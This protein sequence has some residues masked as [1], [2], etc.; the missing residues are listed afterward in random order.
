MVYIYIY[1]YKPL[2]VKSLNARLSQDLLTA[3]NISNPIVIASPKIL[4]LM[5][6]SQLYDSCTSM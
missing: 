5:T 2:L 4:Q 6:N 3:E 1:I